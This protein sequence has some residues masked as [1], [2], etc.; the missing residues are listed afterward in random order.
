MNNKRIGTII[1]G[2]LG[3]CYEQLCVIRGLRQKDPDNRWI[4]FF[5]V[6]ERLDAIRHF[7][8]DMLDEIHLASHI[9]QVTVDYFYQFQVKD[10]ELRRD[11]IDVLPEDIRSK[12]D[13]K[14]NRKPWSHIRSH[15]FKLT[16]LGLELSD[17]GKN[18]LPVCFKENGIDPAIFGRNF[19][20]GYLWRYRSPRGAVKGYF[21][22]S[23]DWI[24]HTKSKLFRRLIDEYD[25]HI[26]ICGM[27]KD[28]K[29]IA[30]MPKEI[31]AEAGF[32]EGEYRCKFAE[33]RLDLPRDRC[34]YL[35]GVGYAAEME[36]MS[37]CDLLLMMP[38]G[39]SEPLW[40]KKKAPVVLVDPPPDYMLKIAWNRMPLFSNLIPR[41]FYCNNFVRHTADN[42]IDFL[43]QQKLLP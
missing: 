41:F 35:K 5:A 30:S 27:N 3:D 21:Q 37:H 24:I 17:V 9:P 34:V 36:I 2:A 14:C 29:V 13:L 11:I 31:L 10:D 25:A 28:K 39:F 40:M 12:F 1:H 20:V 22:Q 4:G 18:Y 16:G 33:E 38:S 15:N 42:I 43:N 26:F 23:K 32:V 6:K 19:T 8:L 7:K